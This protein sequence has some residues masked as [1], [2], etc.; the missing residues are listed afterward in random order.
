MNITIT[1]RATP[2]QGRATTTPIPCAGLSADAL[3]HTVLRTVTAVQ[4]M[5]ALDGTPRAVVIDVRQTAI[6][7]QS[8]E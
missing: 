1:V 3:K 8:G 5:T 4:R 7:T 2:D 6:C